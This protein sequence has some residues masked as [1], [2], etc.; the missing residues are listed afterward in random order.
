MLMRI[1]PFLLML[2]VTVPLSA[3]TIGQVDTFED[4]TTMGWFVPGF[5]PLPPTNVP[6]GG[7]GGPGDAYLQLTASGSSAP[8]GR[9]SAL[10]DAQWAGDYIGAGVTVMVLRV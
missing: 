8:G 10:N 2:A 3:A 4:G 6:T 9:L 7:P 5:S 1:S